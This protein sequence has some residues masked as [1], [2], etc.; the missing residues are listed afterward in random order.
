M[1]SLNF[2]PQNQ[3]NSVFFR[4]VIGHTKIKQQLI[5]AVDEN[6]VSHAQL[7]LGPEGC[8]NLVMA[9]AYAQYINCENRG[10]EDSCGVCPSCTKSAKFIHP[11][12]HYTF[13][14][15]K[16]D[17]KEISSEY[18][19]EWREFLQKTPYANYNHWI[20]SIAADNKQGNITAKECSDILRR[21]S[22]KNF[23]ATYKV[24]IL[25]LPEFLEKEGNRLLKIIEEPPDNTVF[26]LVANDQERVLNTIL[27]R[28]QI[29]KFIRLSDEEIISTLEK[30]FDV[31]L[32]Q[33]KKIAAISDGDLNEA[34][35]LV[36]LQEDGES[37]L[38]REWMEVCYRQNIKGLYAWN[39][40]FVKQGRE[41]QKNFFQYCLHFFR[42]ILLIE[43]GAGSISK[44][45]DAELKTAEGL[46]K[47]LGVE[48][49]TSILELFDKSIYF[50]ERNVN[51][52]ILITYV[53]ITLLKQFQSNYN[54][55]EPFF[56]KW[57][58]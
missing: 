41:S 54:Y 5:K 34:I 12:I 9:L 29:V 19:K 33:A 10:P 37:I 6:R 45:S 46:G 3:N 44:L 23:E 58:I 25:W 53:S 40:K 49:I 20:S 55:H 26:I 22:M 51:A 2:I 8:G 48:K 14:F 11:D 47:L 50:V 43:A 28:L 42:E 38:I 21:L 57:S 56:E 32:A 52:K 17:K 13:P 15:V 1:S 31:S 18:I 7:F 39:E 36:D 27:S 4:D 35:Q 16:T 24:L 30:K